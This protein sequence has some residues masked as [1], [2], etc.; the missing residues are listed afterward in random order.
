MQDILLPFSTLISIP[1]K[2]YWSIKFAII[3]VLYF[4]TTI[5][6]L[7]L[8]RIIPTNAG[9]NS[10]HDDLLGVRI[11]SNLLSG[12]WLGNWDVI[13]LG[14]PPGYSFYLLIAHLFPI[15]LVVFN[16]II[17][18]FLAFTFTIVAKKVILNDSRYKEMICFIS[19][20]ALIFN[21]FLFSTE[22]SRVYR[23]SAHAIF[24]FMYAILVF[25]LL[26][27]IAEYKNRSNS[28]DIFRKRMIRKI[29]MIGFTY[30][31]LIFLRSESF[32]I[33]IAS[34]PPLLFLYINKSF[35]IS[36]ETKKNDFRN[37]SV[38]FI[39]VGLSAYF[40]PV[41]LIGQINSVKYGSSLIENYYSGNFAKAVKDWQ[42]VE[43]GRD[44]R[45]YVVVSKG[46]RDAVYKV[47]KNAAL[48]APSF[49]LKPGEGW[50]THACNAPIHLCDNS[51]AWFPW[52]VRD[53]AIS[54]G[55]IKN[56]IDFQNYF[57]RISQD[58]NTACVNQTLKC[59]PTGLG[60]GAKPLSDL[61]RNQLVDFFFANLSSS[62][63]INL[64]PVGLVATP[65]Q[66]G[67]PGEIV[68]LYHEVV[69]YRASPMNSANPSTHS[70]QL[71]MLQKL[72]FPLQT[73]AFY[74]SII[75][76]LLAWRHKKKKTIYASFGFGALAIILCSGGVAIAQ[77]SYGWRVEGPYLLPIQSI[78][79][80]LCAIGLFS[81]ITADKKIINLFRSNK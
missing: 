16:Q 26:S 42:R 58:I 13:I 66:H 39:F 27:E 11:T 64:K 29:I 4:V 5:A 51:G 79:M 44:L 1:I 68:N 19:Y 12:N 28:L 3:A 60:V 76:Y 69:K 52:Q 23:T 2:K 20:L 45:A 8:R 74:V 49:E 37:S 72:Y 54:T 67:A 33:L 15:Q 59:G 34:L 30:T 35:E 77:V 31:G 48:L 46:Q 65:D 63:P 55:L 80:F 36:K 14:K 22:M 47:S 6:N 53:A 41:S 43:N 50:Q 57:M 9:T 61:P 18:C 17:F 10:P 7:Q 21:P 40:I 75:G 62:L 71:M 24:V 70:S 81:F 25:S 32:W 73:I 56:E 38:F 78:V